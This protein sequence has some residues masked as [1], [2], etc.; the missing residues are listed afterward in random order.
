MLPSLKVTANVDEAAVEAEIKLQRGEVAANASSAPGDATTPAYQQT[1]KAAAGS[2]SGSAGRNIVV[3]TAPAFTKQSSATGA[4]A[5]GAVKPAEDGAKDS[6]SKKRK[7]E[8]E[9]T[10]KTKKKKKKS[11]EEEDEEDDEED[12]E[13]DDDE[14]G[15][16]DENGDGGSNEDGGDGDDDDDEEDSEDE[17]YEDEEDDEDE[18]ISDEE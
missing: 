13:N 5:F 1:F 2:N 17:D 15:S 8:A 3:T 9:D 16:D 7:K 10:S 6:N 12:G 14:N 18:D 4:S 11:E